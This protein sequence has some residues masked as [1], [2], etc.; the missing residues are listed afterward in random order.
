MKQISPELIEKVKTVLIKGSNSAF[1]WEFIYNLIHELETLPKVPD[2][3][4]EQKEP[5]K[6]PEPKIPKPKDLN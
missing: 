3:A 2:P 4:A 1:S 5:V 6:V